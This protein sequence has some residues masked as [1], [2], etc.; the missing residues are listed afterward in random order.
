MERHSPEEEGTEQRFA[1]PWTSAALL[2]FVGCAVALAVG[3]ILGALSATP[4]AQEPAPPRI[5]WR[6]LPMPEK[7]DTPEDDEYRPDAGLQHPCPPK[8]P[9]HPAGGK[10][11]GRS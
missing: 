8:K 6:P 3:F 9:D 5:L 4:P 11:A 7:E 1:L 2:G 10:R